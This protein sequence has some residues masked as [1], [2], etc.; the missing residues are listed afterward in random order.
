MDQTKITCPKCEREMEK[1]FFPQQSLLGLESYWYPIQ[2]D[3]SLRIDRRNRRMI[4][5]YRCASC[6]FL[7][8]YAN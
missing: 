7:E 4:Y 2:P 6:G 8:R 1:G 3:D 5:T